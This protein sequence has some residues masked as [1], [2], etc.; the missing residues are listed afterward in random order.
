MRE[1]A[2]ARSLSFSRTLAAMADPQ[3]VLVALRF[4]EHGGRQAAITSLEG[5]AVRAGTIVRA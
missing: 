2:P 1:R 5:V 3:R 4:V